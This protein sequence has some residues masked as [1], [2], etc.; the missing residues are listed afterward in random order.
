MIGWFAS[1]TG[2]KRLQSHRLV[3]PQLSIRPRKGTSHLLCRAVRKV[4]ERD[5]PD[6]S[7]ASRPPRPAPEDVCERIAR[8]VKG[9]IALTTG[10]SIAPVDNER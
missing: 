3:P 8:R 4:S 5:V 6:T 2:W 7:C 9:L 10:S 1:G